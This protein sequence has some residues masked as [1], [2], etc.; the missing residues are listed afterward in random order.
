MILFLIIITILIII[1]E[2]KNDG[3]NYTK[4]EKR[5]FL[6]YMALS[7]VICVFLL[8]NKENRLAQKFVSSFNDYLMQPIEG[9]FKW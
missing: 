9:I 1:Y 5:I 4:H 3:Y 7:F 2:Y 8:A 6:G